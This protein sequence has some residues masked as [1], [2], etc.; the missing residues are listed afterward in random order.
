MSTKRARSSSPQPYD[1]Y[2]DDNKEKEKEPMVEGLTSQGFLLES[3]RIP[4]KYKDNPT[5]ADIHTE[6]NL[7]NAGTYIMESS[8]GI[9]EQGIQGRIQFCY[10]STLFETI[11]AAAITN[12]VPNEED[13]GK[14]QLLFKHAL[15]GLKL[16]DGK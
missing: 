1:D 12:S 15:D 4:K 11:A 8:G 6:V 7:E 16:I 3:H 13:N 10:T 2:D 5:K 14:L 9:P